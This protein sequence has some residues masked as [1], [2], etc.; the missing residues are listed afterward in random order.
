MLKSWLAA[1]AMMSAAMMMGA[2]ASAADLAGAPEVAPSHKAELTPWQVRLRAVGVLPDFSNRA[3][4][5]NGAILPGARVGVTDTVIPEL[6]IT[7]YFTK[8]I[9]AELILGVTRHTAYGAGSIAG[10]GVL[11]RSWLLP[12]TLTLQY[13]FTD[14]GA[15]KPYIGGGINY[16][17]FFNTNSNALSGFSLRD[18]VGY[19][20]QFGFD[21][22]LNEHWGVNVDAKRIF[23]LTTASGNLGVGGP[24]VTT[25]LRIDPWLVGAGITYRF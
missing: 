16:T 4:T 21:Y 11:G 24:R 18:N 10:L 17:W 19:A 13:H 12:P 15:F 1:G 2:S 8:N 7:Y 5:V 14:F 23:L 22:A 20:V 25:P 6:D 9:A 3:L